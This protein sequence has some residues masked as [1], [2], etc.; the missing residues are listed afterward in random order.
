M[1]AQAVAHRSRCRALSEFHHQIGG[2]QRARL[3]GY[4]EGGSHP[5]CSSMRA[6]VIPSPPDAARL[7]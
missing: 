5:P 7:V 6:N 4:S 2:H 3:D 1:P